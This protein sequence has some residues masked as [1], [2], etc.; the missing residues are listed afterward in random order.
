[1][2]VVEDAVPYDSFVAIARREQYREVLS[3]QSEPF[4]QF[5]AAHSR[6][7]NVGDQ[8]VDLLAVA[9]LQNLERLDAVAGL[10][11]AVAAGLKDLTGQRPDEVFVLDEQNSLVA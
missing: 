11:H 4:R 8:K 1:M 3:I 2:I 6:H 7:Y 9:V 5:P 10:D